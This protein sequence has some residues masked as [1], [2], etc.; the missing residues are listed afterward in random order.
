M[1]QAEREKLQ[2]AI[3]AYHHGVDDVQKA[4]ETLE[5]AN[6]FLAGLKAHVSEFKDLDDEIATSRAAN[7]ENALAAG[8][9]PTLDASPELVAAAAKKVDAENKLAGARAAVSAIEKKLSDLNEK[10]ARLDLEKEWAV[11]A[12]L[13]AEAHGAAVAFNEKLADMRREYFR[14]FAMVNQ[15]VRVD[16]QTRPAP[17]YPGQPVPTKRPIDVSQDVKNAIGEIAVLGNHEERNGLAMR[18]EAANAVNGLF[19]L[20]QYTAGA[21]IEDAML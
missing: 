17:A 7:I 9:T 20:L 6:A 5:R 13:A 11:E 2:A 8:E 16:P 19:S 3:D 10:V 1:S 18:D 21:T 12:V 15:W 14:L 4:G